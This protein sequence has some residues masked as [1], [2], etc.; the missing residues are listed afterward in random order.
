MAR[1]T[2]EQHGFFMR[3]NNPNDFRK[4]LLESSKVILHI[5][6]QIYRVKQIRETKYELM[7]KVSK[8]IQELKILVYKVNE[9]MPMY[10]KEDLKKRFPKID[11]G[12]KPEKVGGA[13]PGPGFEEHISRIEKVSKTLD[14]VHRRLQSI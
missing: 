4:N 9:L 5:L 3:I 11:V 10:K 8:E 1:K 2:T 12:K 14:E 6:K 13:K 7:N